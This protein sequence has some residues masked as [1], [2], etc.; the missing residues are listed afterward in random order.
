[1]QLTTSTTCE[2][3]V[4]ATLNPDGTLSLK[5][6]A[7]AEYAK[8]MSTSAE[9][10]Q[11][12]LPAEALTEIKD[13]LAALLVGQEEKLGVRLQ[14]AIHES[15]RAG[16]VHGEL[17]ANFAPVKALTLADTTTEAAHA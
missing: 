11:S 5:L 7:H 6:T 10:P 16:R 13:K 15:R 17:D 2:V 8:G 3:R 1:M 9:I 4:F 14:H 12:D